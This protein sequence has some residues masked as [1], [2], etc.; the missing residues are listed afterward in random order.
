ML[1]QAALRRANLDVRTHAQATRLLFEDGKAA[2]VAYCHP[3]HPRARAVLA[4]REVI[5]SCGAIN[6]PAASAVWP[7]AGWMLREHGIDVVRDLPGV[8]ENLSDHYSVRVAR[9][10]N[11]QTMNQLVKGLRLAGQIGAG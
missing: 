4:R 3:A 5:V 10:K 8:G 2:G 7:G 1:P 6:T 11:M 9:V